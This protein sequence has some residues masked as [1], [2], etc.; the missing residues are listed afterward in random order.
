MQRK[1][2]QQLLIHIGY[3]KTATTW[4]QNEFFVPLHGYDPILSHDDVFKLITGIHPL[5]FDQ[6]SVAEVLEKRIE[7][8]Q[9]KNLVPVISSEIFSGNPYRGGHDSAENARKLHL[10]APDARILITVREQEAMC[11]SMYMQYISRGG[12]LT[13]TAVFDGAWGLGY[14]GFDPVHLEYDRLVREYQEL[15]GRGNIMVRT[16][17]EFR[18]FPASFIGAISSFAGNTRHQNR[19][20]LFQSQQNLSNPEYAVP[21]LRR[22]NYVRAGPVSPDPIFDFG[23]VARYAYKGMGRLARSRVV[24]RIVREKKPIRKFVRERFS[25][26][27]VTSNQELSQ[28]YPDIDLNGYQGFDEFRDVTHEPAG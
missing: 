20:G 9:E 27:F 7:I 28:I 3:H 8:A 26:R 22:L 4:L 21:M 19:P 14:P 11:V 5:A 1:G 17:E 10:V 23:A 12:S 25:E 18:Q 2:M 16:Y 6:V 15:F 24:E 13:P